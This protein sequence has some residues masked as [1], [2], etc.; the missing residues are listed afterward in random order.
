LTSCSLQVILENQG[1]TFWMEKN[2]GCG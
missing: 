1:Y 2:Y